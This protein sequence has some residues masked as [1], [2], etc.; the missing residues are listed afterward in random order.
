MGCVLTIIIIAKKDVLTNSLVQSG[1][2]TINTTH[3][4]Y[5]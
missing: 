2:T 3:A 1:I 5:F 4:K